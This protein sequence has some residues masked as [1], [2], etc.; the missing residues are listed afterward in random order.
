MDVTT[1]L[2]IFGLHFVGDYLLQTRYMGENKSS[3]NKAL[4]LH[5]IVYSLPFLLIGF[6]YAILNGILH[7]IVDYFS[8]RSFKH[9][10]SEN[11]KFNAIAVMGLDQYIHTV[12]L[13]ITYKILY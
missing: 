6:W 1:L 12:C 5:G 13:I 9:Y 10:W 2:L 7:I 4:L 3:S 11:N 8:S